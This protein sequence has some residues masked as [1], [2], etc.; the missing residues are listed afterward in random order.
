LRAVNPGDL[1]ILGES[2]DDM[3]WLVSFV[4]DDGPVRYYVWDRAAQKES[5]L[6][7][8]RPA[9]SNYTLA[10]ME[11]F[12]Y[13]ASDGL[14][15]HGYL[16]FPPDVPREHLPTVLLVHGGPWVRTTWGLGLDRLRQGVHQRRQPGVG[17][18]D[19]DRPGR[20]RRLGRRPGLRRR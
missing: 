6:F 1:G 4:A 7:E 14:T 10:S 18:Q 11:P 12:S 20:R 8:H 9:L 19:A 13:D 2:D 15:I 16:T 17:R 3:T 5:F